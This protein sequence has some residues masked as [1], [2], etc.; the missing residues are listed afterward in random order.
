MSR[1]KAEP[2]EIGCSVKSPGWGRVL[3]VMDYHPHRGQIQIDLGFKVT[4]WIS[5]YEVVKVSPLVLLAMQA[6]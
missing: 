5:T 6:E 4:Q 3:R 1:P 2:F